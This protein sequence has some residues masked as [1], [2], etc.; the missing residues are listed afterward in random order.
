MKIINSADRFKALP[1]KAAKAQVKAA[2]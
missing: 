1:K 2:P